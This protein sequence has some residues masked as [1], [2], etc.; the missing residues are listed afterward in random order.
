[1]NWTVY[2]ENNSGLPGNCISSVAI[3]SQGYKW[4]GTNG[5]V[6]KYDGSNWTVYNSDNSGLPSNRAYSIAI[7]NQD[8][9]WFGT[10]SGVAKF[11]GANWT[12]YDTDNSGLPNNMLRSIAIDSQQNK[13]FG[14]D[15]GVGVLLTEGTDITEYKDTNSH[16]SVTPN[17]ITTETTINFM[18]DASE[19]V[20]ITITDLSGIEIDKP[21]NNEFKSA[22]QHSVKFIPNDLSAGVYFCT[23]RTDIYSETVKIVVE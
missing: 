20:S 7:D 13:W 3:D 5:A 9:K 10:W 16:L 15:G 19:N 17:P 11:D 4:L 8:N 6:A 12:I 1:V 14:T 21:I 23:L 18:L 2:N 22:G